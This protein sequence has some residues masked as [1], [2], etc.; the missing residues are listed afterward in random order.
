MTGAYITLVLGYRLRDKIGRALKTRA[1]AI[2]R[3]LDNYNEAATQLN[4]P[5]ERLSWAKACLIFIPPSRH[6]T[7]Q[8]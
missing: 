8:L 5:R 1:D 2:K 4:P 7:Y 3:A 6:L